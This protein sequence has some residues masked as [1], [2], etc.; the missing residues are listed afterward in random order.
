MTALRA[1]DSGFADYKRRVLLASWARRAVIAAA[2]G[3]LRHQKASAGSSI[4]FFAPERA[5]RMW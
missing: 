1:N 3:V 5:E 4:R 2:G